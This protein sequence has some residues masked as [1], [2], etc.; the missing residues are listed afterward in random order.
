MNA[1]AAR[2]RVAKTGQVATI[3][4]RQTNSGFITTTSL[5]F[6]LGESPPGGGAAEALRNVHRGAA[7]HGEPAVWDPGA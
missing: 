1:Y 3:R 7:P 2:V 5:P 4:H 6:F